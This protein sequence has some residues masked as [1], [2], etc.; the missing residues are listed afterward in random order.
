MRLIQVLIVLGTLFPTAL[1]SQKVNATKTGEKWNLIYANDENGNRTSGD[2]RELIAAVRQ[3]E[4]IRIGWT[5]EHP[6]NK[7]I[8]LE[9]YADAKF[10]TIMNDSVVFAQID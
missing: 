3:G 5:I 8:R 6:V 10:I 1:L 9:H 7:S 2:L 4:S